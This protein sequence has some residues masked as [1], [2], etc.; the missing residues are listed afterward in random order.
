M[1]D[2]AVVSIVL[3]LGSDAVDDALG[4]VACGIIGVAAVVV[5]VY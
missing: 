1:A 2:E 4:A 5:A 3:I